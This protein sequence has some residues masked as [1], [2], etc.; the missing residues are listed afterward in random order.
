MYCKK[1][2]LLFSIPIRSWT[3][4]RITR[5]FRTSQ[6]RQPV[7][8]IITTL[9]LGFLVDPING[10]KNTCWKFQ[11]YSIRLFHITLF[12]STKESYSDRLSN[13]DI[14]SLLTNAQETFKFYTDIY[15]F[16]KPLS[17][18]QKLN[19]P[20]QVTHVSEGFKTTF[21]DWYNWQWEVES[22]LA[23]LCKFLQNRLLRKKPVNHVLRVALTSHWATRHKRIH[24][25]F[26][27]LHVFRAGSLAPEI[28]FILADLSSGDFSYLV[29]ER[30]LK[31]SYGVESKNEISKFLQT[32]QIDDLKHETPLLTTQICIDL[33]IILQSSS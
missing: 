12:P 15:V 11:F 32:H 16:L 27:Y 10:L 20:H 23:S 5:T 8:L 31:C 17:K 4:E 7:S 30:I 14:H 29:F 13:P 2:P 28:Y 25:R 6:T 1:A 22:F 9:Y 18:G 21:P 26:G 33:S 24:L 19:K 3:Q